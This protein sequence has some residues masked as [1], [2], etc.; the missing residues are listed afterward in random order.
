MRHKKYLLKALLLPTMLKRLGEGSPT[1]TEVGRISYMSYEGRC[2]ER[3][4]GHRGEVRVE[5]LV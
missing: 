1:V 4:L 2:S 3:S 5:D